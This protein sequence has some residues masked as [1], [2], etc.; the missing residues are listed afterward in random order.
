[1]SHADLFLETADI[2]TSSAA[3]ASRFSGVTGRWLLQVQSEATLSM[4]KPYR[5]AKILEVGGG[6][7][8]LTSHLIAAG[9]SVTVLGSDESCQTQIRPLVESGQCKFQVGDVMALPYADNSFDVVISYRFLAHVERWQAFLSELGRVA[10]QAVLVDYP[11][12]CSVNYIAPLLFSFKKG[13]EGNTR[14]YTCYNETELLDYAKSLGL[15]VGDRYAQF[16]W[17][18]V[19]HRMLKTPQVS[20]V[21][22]NGARQLGLSQ[23][24]GSPVITKFIKQEAPHHG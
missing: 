5:T 12:L 18:M 23:R 7:G 21:L 20:M 14:P 3:Y 8:Q 1:M 6:H 24:L 2:E 13:V 15:K 4:L 11:T 9:H 19:L 17:P 16:F 22:E 10:S